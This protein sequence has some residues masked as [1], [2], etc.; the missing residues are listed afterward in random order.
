[1]AMEADRKLKLVILCLL[2][3]IAIP[4]LKANIGMF[5]DVWEQRQKE[6]EQA[7][8]AAYQHDPLKHVVH[9]NKQVHKAMKG[10]ND[11]RRNL[12]H[13]VDGPCEAINPIDKCW[14]CDPNWHENR[15]KLAD[16]AL[17][18]GH[19]TTGG[20]GGKI[21]VVTDDT[22]ED[23]VN[24]KEGTLRYAVTR[25]EPLWII[26]EED[27][28]IELK[29]ELMMASNKTIDGRGVNVRIQGG[30]QITLQYVR[31]II[32]S[33]IRVRDTIPKNGG[34]IRDSINHYG[35]RTES[36]GDAISL[37]GATNVWIDHISASNCADGLIDVIQASTAITI[38]NSH[39]TDHNDVMLF[40][41]SDS[42]SKDEIM[43]ITLAF[44]HFGQGLVQRMPRC[45]FGFFHV[46]NNDYT[47]WIMYAIG[48]S[49]H[50]TI[51]SQGNRYIAPENEAAKEVCYRVNTDKSVW[52]NWNWH[53]DKDLFVNGATFTESGGPVHSIDTKD[54][55]EP[56]TGT[57]VTFLTRYAGPLK[58]RK[59]RGC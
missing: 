29:Q 38:S 17:G 8:K 16:C 37:F 31:N 22:D 52:K 4:V 34:M 5:D 59:G 26:F 25:P 9:L 54:M 35:L 55:I 12:R 57:A 33:N 20:K 18:F 51:L 11:T 58:C 36:D 44:N 15:Q 2:M 24:P 7:A 45:R 46:V 43:Q 19:G 50:P 56:K 41:S 53:S 13:R 49:S 30:G 3:S 21:Y 1:M 10:H 14:R 23:M 48:G 27:M 28:K 6:A 42:N 39:F 32:I 40:G 47:Q